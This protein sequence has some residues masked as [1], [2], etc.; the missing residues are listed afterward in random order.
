MSASEI[1]LPL[2]MG[3]HTIWT[4]R[5]RLVPYR[6][7][8]AEALAADLPRLV[9]LARR[10]DGYLITSVPAAWRAG[11]IAL[12]PELRA[13]IRQRYWRRYARLD[14][15][16]DDYWAGLSAKGRSTLKRKSR[17]LA[18]RS[19]GV[20]AISC[21]RTPEEIRA[22]HA[23][24]REV[25]KLSYQERL[26]DAGL[27][28]GPD[29]LADMCALASRDAVRAWLLH[30]DGRAIAY[31]YAPAD[32]DVLLYAHLGYDPAHAT[33]SPGSVLQI[34]AMRQLMAEDRFRFFD[35]TEGDGQHKRQ[36][37]TDGIDCVDLLLVR[38]TLSNLFVTSILGGFDGFLAAAKR[39]L[40]ASGGE[41]RIRSLLR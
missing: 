37:A 41:S 17:K 22:F 21:H 27:P 4:L 6:L 38:P 29:A 8:L 15:A 32:G 35:F 12:H 1:A 14:L 19:G 31:L 9:P 34:E 10:D 39:L 24:A 3:A 28:D 2:Q 20:L 40:A 11:L 26:L 25:S 16:F 33:L 7:S 30:L 13:F 36:F 18:V 23:A 5:R